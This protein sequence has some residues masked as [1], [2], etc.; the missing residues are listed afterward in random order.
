MRAFVGVTDNDWY[1][2]L[3]AQA[4]LDEVNFWQPSGR[5]R[6]KALS[7]GQLFLFKLKSPRN[8]IA[9]GGFLAYSSVLPIGLAWDAFGVKN[10][11]SSYGELCRLISGKR[12]GVKRIA[13][14]DPIG[15]IML[16]DPFFFDKRDW[17]A[18]PEFGKEIVVGKGFNLMEGPGRDLWREVEVRLR[19]LNAPRVAEPIGPAMGA[20]S[21][22]RQRRGQGVFRAMITDIYHRRCAVTAEKALPVLEAA[23]IRPV[24]KGGEH[25]LDNGL[26]LR[27][28]VHRLFD[29]GYV[30]VTPSLEFRVSRELQKRFDDGETYRPFER[31]AIW[32]PDEADL[33]PNPEFLEWHNDEVF[34]G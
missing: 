11:T 7:P 13:Y 1:D 34:V 17:F 18:A 9:G 5:T 6:F 19:G 14:G 20:M 24:H 16:R 4:D 12:K 33:R 25:R 2:F 32:R 31:H 15:C 10:G 3:R 27:S 30:T 26:L 22:V 28:D 23:H 29:E 8:V 21:L